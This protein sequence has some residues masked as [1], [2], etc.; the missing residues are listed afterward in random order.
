MGG[1]ISIV[2]P[3][4]LYRQNMQSN[5]VG[6]IAYFTVVIL[7][8]IL[9]IYFMVTK[10]V[11]KPLNQLIRYTK[12]IKTGD[13]DIH[14]ETLNAVGELKDLT[15]YFGDMTKQ[16]HSLYNEL[17][18]KIL[19][20]TEDLERANNILELQ[21]IQLEEAN[22]SLQDDNQYKSEFLAIVS[23][24]LRTPLTSII[25][26]AEVLE[27]AKET[28]GTKEQRMI[29]EIKHNS[30]KLLRMINSILEMARLEAGKLQLFLELIDLVDVV[31]AV[32]S[33]V[34][35][36]ADKKNIHFTTYVHRDVPVI[37]ADRERVHQI[38]ENLVSNAIKFTPDGGKVTVSVT[39]D[40]GDNQVLIYVEDNGIG[41]RK[42]DQPFIFEK[43]VQSDT[44]IYRKYN[45]SGLGLALAKD[46]AELH[47]G[48]IAVSSEEG[49]G[50]LF[51]VGIP[52]EEDKEGDTE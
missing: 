14:V 46:L 2:M 5:V 35:P 44:T 11:T 47:G 28:K 4:E 34:K 31:N 33:V 42:E 32:E 39:Y 6:E 26:F 27:R 50:S 52:V 37:E 24:E 23:H 41:I 8:L 43:F 48:W 36:I 45:G 3:I 7:L 40:Q 12:Q 13:W 16:L 49:T 38:I 9:G 1:V 19:L 51:T 15:D 20:R 18:N 17:E 10:L 22:C 29:E 21:R 25:A 30:Q